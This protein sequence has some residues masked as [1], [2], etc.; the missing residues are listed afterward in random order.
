MKQKDLYPWTHGAFLWVFLWLLLVMVMGNLPVQAVEDP[1][2]TALKIL[3]KAD[4]YA[5]IGDDRSRLKLAQKAYELAPLRQTLLTLAQAH[6]E[7]GNFSE[8]HR[9]WQQAQTLPP[10]F[11]QEA[12][13]IAYTHVR[14]LMLQGQ[15]PS[16]LESWR[17]HFSL[18][19]S[20][21]TDLGDRLR[22]LSHTAYLSSC[23]QTHP[24]LQQLSFQD[25]LQCLQLPHSDP[26]L[27]RVIFEVGRRQRPEALPFLWP[28]LAHASSAEAVQVAFVGLTAY[29]W[30]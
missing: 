11:G 25:L 7:L 28:L 5:R 27:R 18:S 10:Y 3:K 2:V 24:H 23:T 8:A 22:I 20:P 30:Q 19:Q 1:G 14:W 17:D 9:Y 21:E 4:F 29:I 16:A 12:E 15:Y 26:S 13:S 6:T